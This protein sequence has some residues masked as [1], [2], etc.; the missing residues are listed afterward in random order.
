MVVRQFD[1]EF[2]SKVTLGNCW[3]ISTFV[4]IP[5]IRTTNCKSE[6]VGN[7]KSL[8]LSPLTT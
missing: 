6:M 4:C 5:S 2:F 1:H 8:V 3:I 7:P